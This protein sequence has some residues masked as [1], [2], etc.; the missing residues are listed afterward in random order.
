MT[1]EVSD[2]IIALGGALI[3]FVLL[4]ALIMYF[5]RREKRDALLEQRDEALLALGDR[6]A[7]RVQTVENIVASEAAELD[8]CAVSPELRSSRQPG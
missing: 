4:P 6:L 1:R 3:L 8:V 5:V 2:L 7:D